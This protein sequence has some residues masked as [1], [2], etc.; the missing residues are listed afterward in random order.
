MEQKTKNGRFF[1]LRHRIRSSWPVWFYFLN[2]E[3]RTLWRKKQPSLSS[4]QKKV[5]GNLKTDG[6][7]I[8]SVNE[9]FESDSLFVTLRQYAEKLLE[10][11]PSETAGISTTEK[12][13]TYFKK[14]NKKFLKSLIDA[15]ENALP[16]DLGNP[17]LQ[18]TFDTKMLDTVSAYFEQYPKFR[19]Y[20]LQMTLKVSPDDPGSFSQKW[21]RDPEDKKVIKIFVYISDVDEP[22][23]GPFTYVKG[24]QHGGRWRHLFPQVPPLGSYPKPGAV[25]AAVPP[26]DIKICMGKAGTLIFCDTSGL[27]RGGLCTVKKRL[28]Y[29]GCF[30]S[31][32]SIHPRT[33][34]APSSEALKNM[35]DMAA[36]SLLL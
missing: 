11:I 17:F 3:P 26:E 30:V 7:A 18:L 1:W 13:D 32:A 10:K 20:T 2:R 23:A 21:H 12:S 15:P 4:I 5:L 14:Y 28:M 25:E 33:F 31:K 29:T 34:T 8:V 22:G 19:N 6:L 9:F 16:I 27:H 24:S 35:S 36:Y